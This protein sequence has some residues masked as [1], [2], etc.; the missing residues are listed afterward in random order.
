M[1]STGLVLATTLLPL[2]KPLLPVLATL[3]LQ[4]LLPLPRR[5]RR[6]LARLARRRVRLEP[7]EAQVQLVQALRLQLLAHRTRRHLHR[8]RILRS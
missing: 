3:Q 1:T 2:L 4:L 5:A 7:R 6:V 8:L